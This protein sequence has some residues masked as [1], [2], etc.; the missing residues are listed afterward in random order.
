MLY[1]GNMKQCSKCHQIKPL[2]E[3]SFKNRQKG[4]LV[5]YCKDCNRT[6]QKVHYNDNQLD[7]RIKR[8]KWRI[9]FRSEIREK[10]I[11]HF[12]KYPCVDCGETDYT[13]LEFDH[14]RGDKKSNI[15][16]LVCNDVSWKVIEGEIK[17]CEVRC[18]NC[19]KRRSAKQF[20]WYKYS[21]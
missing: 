9:K 4:W 21:E 20:G 13:V 3:F 15:A 7:Y 10:I 2:S 14:V 8:K 19:H 11:G 6:Y 16:S 1:I 18:A 5:S 12:K 17:K